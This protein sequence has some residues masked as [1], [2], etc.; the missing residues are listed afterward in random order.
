MFLVQF[1]FRWANAHFLNPIQ[2]AL[3]LAWLLSY[4]FIFQRLVGSQKEF[5]TS[6]VLSKAMVFLSGLIINLMKPRH[7]ADAWSHFVCFCVTWPNTANYEGVLGWVPVPSLSTHR[8]RR[9][10]DLGPKVKYCVCIALVLAK[11]LKWR[12]FFVSENGSGVFAFQNGIVLWNT[13]LLRLQEF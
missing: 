3:S 11:S 5:G 2:N 1:S 13:P 7:F 6:K 9:F 8:C 4:E 12:F 10:C